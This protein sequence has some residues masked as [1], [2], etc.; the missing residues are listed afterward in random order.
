MNIYVKKEVI[1]IRAK[2]CSVTRKTNESFESLLKRFKKS[3][4][5]SAVLIEYKKHA[6]YEAPSEKAKR[7]HENALKRLRKEER[8]KEKFANRN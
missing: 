4:E 6:Y 3:V 2:A 1:T 5:K 7:K 8:L